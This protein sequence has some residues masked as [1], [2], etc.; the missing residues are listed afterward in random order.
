MEKVSII[1]KLQLISDYW[2][3]IIVGELNHQHV[4]LVKVKGDFLMHKHEREDELF[5]VLKGKL[6]IDYGDHN[7]EINEGEFI[8]VPKGTLHRPFSEKETHL[9]LFEPI[10]TLNTGNLHNELT[11]DKPDIK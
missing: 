10:S 7:K 1:E 4:K 3:P 6:N 11:V 8:I 5:F 9:L 2:N